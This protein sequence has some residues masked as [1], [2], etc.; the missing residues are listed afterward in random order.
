MPN[1]LHKQSGHRAGPDSG[2]ATAESE[3][4][5]ALRYPFT[6][7]VEVLESGS[8]TRLSA[9]LCD[10]SL[11]GCYIDTLNP[12]PRGTL[13]RLRFVKGK[14]VFETPARVSYSHPG[15]GMGVVFADL[16]PDRRAVLTEWLTEHSTPVEPAAQ[17]EQPAAKSAEPRQSDR[18]LVVGLLRVLIR[19]GIVTE[20]EAKTLLGGPLP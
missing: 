2:A 4:R 11:E 16:T 6:A 10:L 7:A 15:L 20:S 9:R 8:G 3:R 1:P 5:G 19:K 13:V 12:F 17:P 14:T 18:A